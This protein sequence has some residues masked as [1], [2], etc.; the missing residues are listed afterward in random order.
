[1][2]CIAENSD[3]ASKLTSSIPAVIQLLLRPGRGCVIYLLNILRVTLKSEQVTILS[4]I[5]SVA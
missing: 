4:K 3:P 1:M 2:L 5:K